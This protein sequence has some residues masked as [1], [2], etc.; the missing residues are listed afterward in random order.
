MNPGTFQ[1]AGTGTTPQNNNTDYV[2][3]PYFL[4]STT[5][6]IPASGWWRVVAVGAGGSGAA[7]LEMNSGGRTVELGATGGGAGGFCYRLAYVNA[8]TVLNITIGASAASVQIVSGD[9]GTAA[10]N[11]TAGGTT[12]VVGG[13][14]NMF[15]LGGSG[16]IYAV[17]ASSAASGGAGGSAVGGQI[18]VTGGSGGDITSTTG[19]NATGGGAVGVFGVGYPGGSISGS[20]GKAI[21]TGGGGVGG[22]GSN[23]TTNANKATGGGSSTQSAPDNIGTTTVVLG[24]PWFSVGQTSMIPQRSIPGFVFTG[25]ANAG[26]VSPIYTPGAGGVAALTPGAAGNGGLFAGGGG[27]CSIDYPVIPSGGRGGQAATPSGASVLQYY[28]GGGGGAVNYGLNIGGAYANTGA[29]GNGIVYMEYVG[30]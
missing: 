30:P 2:L 5:Y 3:A 9:P 28:G 15:A 25:A 27:G 1:G 10:V 11:G 13:P 23:S 22:R 8:N 16:G 18:N 12:S 17:G 6:K 26:G 21:S 29:S 7:A 14:F 4:S 19:V 24:T 20:T